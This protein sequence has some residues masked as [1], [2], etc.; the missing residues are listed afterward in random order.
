MVDNNSPVKLLASL[1]LSEYEARAYTALIAAQPASAY[2]LAK[3]AG[4]PTS[5]IYQILAQLEE[6]GMAIPLA[7]KEER[8]RKFAAS[9]PDEYLAAKKE[10]MARTTAS[11]A[12]LLRQLA[13]SGEIGHVWPM[14]TSDVVIARARKMLTTASDRAL[15]SLWPDEYEHLQKELESAL[16][17][18]LKVAVV[19][20]GKPQTSIGATFHHPVERAI[21]REKGGRELILVVD[22]AEAMMA[23]FME[24]GQVEGAWSRNRAFVSATEDFIRHDVYITKVTAIMG[25]LMREKFGDNYERLRDVFLAAEEV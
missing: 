21:Y 14:A 9:D 8:G 5:R 3:R 19:H 11:L 6:K 16:D 24:S 2:E 22:G 13:P 15:V 18:G 20:F 7:G 10:E 17:R 4:M 25:D 1:G 23:T 12:P